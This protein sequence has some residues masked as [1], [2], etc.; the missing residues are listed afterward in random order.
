MFAQ[1]ETFEALFVEFGE[2]DITLLD[3]A[4]GDHMGYAIH[5]KP[6]QEADGLGPLGQFP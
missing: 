5:Y 4:Y 3:E 2:P 1:I 6:I